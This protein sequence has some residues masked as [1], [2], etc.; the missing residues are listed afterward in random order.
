MK[1]VDRIYWNEKGVVLVSMKMR[2]LLNTLKQV[3]NGCLC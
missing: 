2:D 1:L 3:L